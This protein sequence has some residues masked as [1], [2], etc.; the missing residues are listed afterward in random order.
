VKKAYWAGGIVL[1]LAVACAA[2]FA[3]VRANNRAVQRELQARYDEY[4]RAV[5]ARDWDAVARYFDRTMLRTWTARTLRG[6]VVPLAQQ[7]RSFTEGGKNVR[8]VERIA[9]NVERVSVIWRSAVATYTLSGST[10]MTGPKGRPYRQTIQNTL[11]SIW[12]YTPQGWKCGRTVAIEENN[13]SQ[14]VNEKKPGTHP[15]RP[16]AKGAA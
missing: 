2:L 9:V 16:A 7:K 3:A 13:R 14:W 15:Q 1:P 11:R 12:V 6:Q 8:A 10:L 5:K 4:T